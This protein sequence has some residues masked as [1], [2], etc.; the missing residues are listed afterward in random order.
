MEDSATNLHRKAFDSCKLSVHIWLLG[1][2]PS[3]VMPL[4]PAFTTT[5]EPGYATAV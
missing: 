4:D 1:A 2:L 5:P 3:G